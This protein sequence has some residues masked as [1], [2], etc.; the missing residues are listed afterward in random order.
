MAQ[1]YTL[2][3]QVVGPLRHRERVRVEFHDRIDAVVGASLVER[4]D[5]RNVVI[6]QLH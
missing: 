2:L 5:A 6:G 4:I 3:A 1:D